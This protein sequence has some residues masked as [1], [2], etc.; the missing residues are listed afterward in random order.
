MKEQ[1]K[2]GY[3][4]NMFTGHNNLTE[5]EGRLHFLDSQPKLEPNCCRDICSV[6]ELA[7]ALVGL[8]LADVAEKHIRSQFEQTRRE[9][10]L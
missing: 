8:F 4:G 2:K 9:C 6:L 3:T 7:A 10:M 1:Q 5:F